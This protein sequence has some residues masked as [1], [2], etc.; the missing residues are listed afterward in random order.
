M[1][2]RRGLALLVVALTAGP[3]PLAA[4][5]VKVGDKVDRLTFTDIHYLPRSLDDFPGAK[6]FVLAFTN[7]GCPVVLSWMRATMA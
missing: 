5:E 7:T 2:S 6:A 3:A 1:R 4:A